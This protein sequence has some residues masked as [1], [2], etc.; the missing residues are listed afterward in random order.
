MAL[1]IYVFRRHG[2]TTVNPDKKPETTFWPDQVLKD[3]VA[4]LGVLV[5]VLVLVFRHVPDYGGGEL[6]RLAEEGRLGEALGA[7]LGAPADPSESY[8]AARPE[9]YF[10]FLFQFLKYFPGETEI[11]GAVVIPGLV[12]GV[13]FFMPFIGRWKNGHLFNIGYMACLFVGIATLTYQAIAEDRSKPEYNKAVAEAEKNYERAIELAR[14]GIGPLGMLA[15]LQNDP[16]TSGPGLFAMHCSSCHRFDGH[17]GTGKTPKDPPTASD[18]GKFGQRAWI[19]GFIKNP[20]GEHYFGPTA[21]AVFK[22]EPVELVD[23]E[24]ATWSADNASLMTDEE[25]DGVAEFLVSLGDRPKLKSPDPQ[26]VAVGRRFFEE[27]QA[28]DEGATACADCHAIVLGEETLGEPGGGAPNLT[29]YGSEDW[30]RSFISNPGAEEHYGEQNA[31]PAFAERL[32][33]EQLDLLV[34]WLRQD[35]YEPGDEVEEADK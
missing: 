6:S 32:S 15:E 17:D 23:G 25:L 12:F 19:K 26:L 4:C 10:L 30:L 29:G 1:H 31:M 27:G 33:P 34:R 11:Y 8:A 13:M 22:G 9:W 5:V 20:A 14:P 28:G 24:M 35:W 3:A 16:K 7:D 2:I 21:R 18:L